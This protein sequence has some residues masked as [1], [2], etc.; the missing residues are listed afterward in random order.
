MILELAMSHHLDAVQSRGHAALAE[1]VLEDGD[2]VV[3]LRAR[4]LGVAA[5]SALGAGT[6]WQPVLVS[7][8]VTL[9]RPGHCCQQEL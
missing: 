7:L 4:H 2:A 6:V 8:L 1:H 9:T 5:H 3:R